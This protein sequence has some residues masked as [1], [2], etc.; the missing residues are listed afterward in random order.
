[1]SVP[2]NASL[3][4]SV[5]IGGIPY[6]PSGDSRYRALI[7]ASHGVVWRA[8]PD[9]ACLETWGWDI[10]TGQTQ[11]QSMGEGWLDV[12]HPEDRQRMVAV[13]DKARRS[14]EPYEGTY[15]ARQADGNY[16]WVHC[17][18]VPMRDATGAIAEWVGHL[19]DVHERIEADIAL[20]RA[21]ERLRLAL[22]TS[23]LVVWEYSLQ[24]DAGW[25]SEGKRAVLGLPENYPIT[26]NAFI[27]MVHPDDRDLFVEQI[28]SAKTPLNGGRFDA[29]FRMLR[30]ADGREVWL[31]SI[32]QVYFDAAGNPERILGTM[33][34][35]TAERASKQTLYSL[36][37]FDQLTGLSNRRHFAE[38]LSEVLPDSW[39]GA[40]ILLDLD[41]FKNANDTM[42][43]HT[44]DLLLQAAANRL[45]NLL[46]QAAFA[47]RWGG[48]EFV[49]FVPGNDTETAVFDLINNIEAAFDQPFK[50]L[51]RQIAISVSMGVAFIRTKDTSPEELLQQAD[52]ALY[53]AKG[54]GRGIS[55][56]FSPA[57]RE[58]AQTRLDLEA[59]LRRAFTSNELELYYQ[60][61][62]DMNSAAIVGAEALLRW[63]H[64]ERGILAPST[65]I[66]V[67]ATSPIARGV[68]DWVLRTACSFA[69]KCLWAGKPVR[70][71]VNIFNAQI[72]AGGL[73]ETVRQCLRQYGLPPDLLELE[74]TE[75]TIL[76]GDR[77]TIETL[78]QLRDLGVSIAFD[79]Y[80]T[81]YASLS[82]LTD[83]PLTRLKIDKNFVQGIVGSGERAVVKAIVDLGHAFGMRVTAEG[84]ETQEQAEAVKSLGCDEGQGF[85]YSRPVP[86]EAFLS[87]NNRG[88]SVEDA[89]LNAGEASGTYAD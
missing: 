41:G 52:L 84:I 87:Q 5:A 28:E 10:A 23:A 36:A 78:A 50:L 55:R 76:K 86:P 29:E 56:V 62:V 72:R 20:R 67:L 13:L 64:P 25:W 6:A 58:E 15:R 24:S 66:D 4:R 49:I 59:D 79:D 1:M 69:T 80:G 63:R 18:C 77:R 30:P 14:G 27:A 53:R 16:R 44:G 26:R 3:V 47:A 89:R 88:R 60:A 43:H 31:A 42:G 35:V 34:D 8:A 54:D 11:A 32:G 65:F 21:E 7:E 82:M 22:E 45:S 40:V 17:R 39:G 2:E 57:M 51:P 46:P 12:V 33:R 85:L 73:P 68:G 37:H 61:Q 83:Y 19:V 74:I 81:G 70:M 71:G 75:Q 48:D 38:R 9:L